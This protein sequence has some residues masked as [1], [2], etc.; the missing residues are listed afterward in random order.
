MEPIANV[1]V[2]AP[3]WLRDPLTVLL[4][5][6]PHTRVWAYETSVGSLLA[7][8]TKGAPD[9]ILLYVTGIDA[10]AKVREIR[11]AWPA[12]RVVALV[13]QAQQQAAVRCAGADVVLI[14]GL[15]PQRLVQALTETN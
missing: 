8:L 11:V 7:A 5:A 1:A 14:Q 13:E 10:E 4:D 6:A 2:I 15:A 3:A 12:L 9:V